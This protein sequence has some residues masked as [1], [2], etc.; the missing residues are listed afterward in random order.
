MVPFWTTNSRSTAGGDEQ[1]PL[2]LL[3]RAKPHNPV[4]SGHIVP[5]AVEEH[6]L[7][8]CREMRDLALDIDLRLL[9]VGG[10]GCHMAEDAR[11]RG[12]GNPADHAAFPCCVPPLKDH[13]NACARGLGLSLQSRKLIGASRAPFQIPCA[14]FCRIRPLAQLRHA[15]VVCLFQSGKPP[16]PIRLV[17]RHPLY[18]HASPNQRDIDQ[19]QSGGRTPARSHP[20]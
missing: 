14:A 17:R 15:S 10:G 20:T 2:V 18:K 3:F 8:R 12:C 1:E 11:A 16:A 5:R 4:V 13:D 9:A 19:H 6:D 7:A